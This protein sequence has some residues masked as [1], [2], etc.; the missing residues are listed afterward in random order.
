MESRLNGITAAA[1]QWQAPPLAERDNSGVFQQP[2]RGN[3]RDR[4]PIV[5][6]D[7]PFSRARACTPAIL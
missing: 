5:S 1:R 4:R 6:R 7:R 2:P 3:D